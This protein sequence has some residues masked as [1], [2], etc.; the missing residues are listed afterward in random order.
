[1]GGPLPIGFDTGVRK[2]KAA[3]GEAETVRKAHEVSERFHG[4]GETPRLADREAQDRD[5]QVSCCHAVDRGHLRHFQTNPIHAGRIRQRE[6][7]HNGE[8][9]AVRAVL[10]DG[11][12]RDARDANRPPGLTLEWCKAITLPSDGGKRR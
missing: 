12:V 1:M 5:W 3:T 9:M 4:Q 7:M 2:L 10:S 8:H 6:R 11:I